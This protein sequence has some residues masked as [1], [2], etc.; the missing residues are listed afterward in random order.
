M[1]I[2]ATIVDLSNRLLGLFG[3]IVN[4]FNITDWFVGKFPTALNSFT[5]DEITLFLTV[6]VG[7]LLTVIVYGALI[8]VSKFTL[9]LLTFAKWATLVVFISGIIISFI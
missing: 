3:T 9:N 1:D 8:N 7:V 6:I 5:Y 2:R 4:M